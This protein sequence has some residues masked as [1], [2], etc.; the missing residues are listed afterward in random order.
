MGTVTP[1]FG[2]AGSSRPWIE[3]ISWRPRAY[4]FHNLLS[5][6]EVEHVLGIAKDYIERSSVQNPVTGASELNNVR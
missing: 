4:V 6:E 3:H 5:N 2:L 1:A